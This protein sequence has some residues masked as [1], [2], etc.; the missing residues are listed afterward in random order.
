MEA[1]DVVMDDNLKEYFEDLVPSSWFCRIDVE[2]LLGISHN[3]SHACLVRGEADGILISRMVGSK[4]YYRRTAYRSDDP[5]GQEYQIEKMK[6]EVDA[7]KVAARNNVIDRES[8]DGWFTP[9]EF[10]DRENIS[11]ENDARIILNYLV[12]RGAAER[13]E[14]GSN[15]RAYFRLI[16]GVSL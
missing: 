2:I 16:K 15:R 10:A 6:S 7:A 3:T 11:T 1:T 4:K 14:R 5:A 13:K 12:K 9:F 8:E